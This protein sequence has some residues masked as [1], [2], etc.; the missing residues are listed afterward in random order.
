LLQQQTQKL[1]L[2]IAFITIVNGF[3]IL[4][5]AGW[6]KRGGKKLTKNKKK[7]ETKRIENS[8]FDK[9]NLVSMSLANKL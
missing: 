5:D 9:K 7:K 3:V 6:Q 8:Q 2:A 1:I 4:A